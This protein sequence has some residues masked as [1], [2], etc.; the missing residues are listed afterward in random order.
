[1]GCVIRRIL[2]SPDITCPGE[3]CVFREL[4]SLFLAGVSSW[5]FL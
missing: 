2:G 4:D 5:G 3:S 1:M